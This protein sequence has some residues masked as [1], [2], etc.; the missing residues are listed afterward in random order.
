M[1]ITS[2][3]ESYIELKKLLLTTNDFAE[4]LNAGI[5]DHNRLTRKW[6]QTRSDMLKQFSPEEN[7]QNWKRLILSLNK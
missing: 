4:M 7:L 3:L 5:K 6:S 2:P 1:T